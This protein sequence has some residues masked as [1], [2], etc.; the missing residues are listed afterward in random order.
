MPSEVRRSRSWAAKTRWAKPEPSRRST[1][2]RQRV[3][4]STSSESTRDGRF[5]PRGRRSGG[6]ALR[7]ARRCPDVD[8]T[9]RRVA[10]DLGELLVREV[11]VVERRD[12]L[13]E[14]RDAAR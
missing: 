5:E 13:L 3:G 11:E 14:L 10:V 2:R 8:V 6:R 1:A 9:F 4:R 7:L 12:V